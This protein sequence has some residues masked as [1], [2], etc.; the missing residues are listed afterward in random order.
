MLYDF[1]RDKYDV[2][3]QAGQSN[4]SGCSLG[5]TDEPYE[6]D[7]RILYMSDPFGGDGGYVMDRAAEN[8]YGNLIC[9]NFSLSFA[10]EYVKRGHLDEGRKLLIVRTAAGGTSF[11]S[12]RWKL[13]GDLYRRML[14][15]AQTALSLNPEN[16]L[17]GILW[18]QGEADAESHASYLEHYN[19][20]MTLV[21]A[22]R[23]TLNAP[24]VPFIAGDMVPHWR[25][26]H[27]DI[28]GPVRDAIR[29]VARA[30]GNGYF[31]ETDE[32]KSNNQEFGYD[33]MGWEDH[34]HFSRRSSYALG[35]KYMDCYEAHLEDRRNAAR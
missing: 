9:T 4:A 7:Q 10:R 13:E 1:S 35:K 30:C 24:G 33:P 15:M 18:H 3:I 17:M 16:R 11:L 21:C 31:I 28:T 2:F 6:E 5:D 12:H 14:D 23:S 20:L 8:I 26:E 19:N 29:D 34:I 27:A 32:L 25:A 22:A